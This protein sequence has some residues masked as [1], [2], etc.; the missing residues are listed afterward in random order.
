MS[1][2]D[3]PAPAPVAPEPVELGRRDVVRRERAQFGSIQPGCAFFVRLSATGMIVVLTA[4]LAAAG[5]VLSLASGTTADQAQATAE[6]NV[7]TIGTAGVVGLI[8]IVMLAYF[9]GGYV[10]GRMARFHGLRQ[11]LAVWAWGVITAVGSRS[12]LLRQ[13]TSTTSSLT[14]TC[15]VSPLMRAR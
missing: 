5:T 12:W 11:G 10:A 15:H 3:N 6:N 14:L 1:K 9:C 7:K 13:V 4:L 8:A 2:D